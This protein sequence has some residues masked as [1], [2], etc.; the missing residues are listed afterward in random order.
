MTTTEPKFKLVPV[1][2]LLKMGSICAWVGCP[3]TF[4]GELPNG[5]TWLQLYWSPQVNTDPLERDWMRDGVLCPEHTLKMDA[6]FKRIPRV[7]E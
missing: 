6:Q 5:W 2:E 3:R 7:A 1:S 4:R